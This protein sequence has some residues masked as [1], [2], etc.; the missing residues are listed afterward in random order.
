M[1][2]TIVVSLLV[3]SVAAQTID[4][5]V[6]EI[7]TCAVTCIRDGAQAV[8]CDV[9]DF[10]CSCSKVGELTSSVV[11]CL[12]T[13][14]CNSSDQASPPARNPDLRHGRRGR[15]SLCRRHDRH[16]YH[17]LRPHRHGGRRRHLQHG[18]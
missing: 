7:P 13:S 3:A 2:Y 17:D 4:Q 5:L 15:A 10:T 6:E 18:T 14:G 9:T 8:N 1:K 12:A 16:R 11:P